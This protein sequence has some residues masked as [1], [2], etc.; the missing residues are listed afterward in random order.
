MGHIYIKNYYLSENQFTQHPIVYLATL[1]RRHILFDY[2][3][4][5]NAK[6]I[7]VS[8]SNSLMLYSNWSINFYYFIFKD[9]WLNQF[10]ISGWKQCFLIK[11][12]HFFYIYSISFLYRSLFHQLGQR[13]QGRTEYSEKF[14]LRVLYFAGLVG[15]PLH[16]GKKYHS[17]LIC[18]WYMTTNSHNPGSPMSHN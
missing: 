5:S 17:L 8:G 10:F 3:T 9:F 7:S 14:K 4:L 1:I 12:S 6:L 11:S 13:V 2:T 18:W 15:I 16:P